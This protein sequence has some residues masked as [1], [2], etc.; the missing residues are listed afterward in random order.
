MKIRERH[1][2]DE[3]PRMLELLV[4]LAGKS[5]HHIRADGRERHPAPDQGETALVV[6]DPVSPPHAAQ[7]GVRPGL[8]RDMNMLRNPFGSSHQLDQVLAPVHGLDR[9]EADAADRGLDENLSQQLDKPWPAVEIA[10]P[11]A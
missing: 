4:G 10:P 2:V 8:Q 5:H 11:A 9:A 6:T 7:H 1:A 3:C